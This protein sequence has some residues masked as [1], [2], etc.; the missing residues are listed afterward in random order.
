MCDL[1]TPENGSKR[2]ELQ[3][4]GFSETSANEGVPHKFA[5]AVCTAIERQTQPIGT[6]VDT[7]RAAARLISSIDAFLPVLPNIP[8]NSVMERLAARNSKRPGSISNSR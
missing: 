1:R 3:V 5:Q 6:E 4:G 7:A 2:M 8:F